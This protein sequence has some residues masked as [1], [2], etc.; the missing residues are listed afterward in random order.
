MFFG[1][2]TSIILVITTLISVKPFA[3]NCQDV[4]LGEDISYSNFHLSSVQL[5]SCGTA[6]SAV[7]LNQTVSAVHLINWA[8][9]MP[10]PQ[11]ML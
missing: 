4:F 10:T 8:G 11:I 7:H 6:V 3:Q 5:N 9:K 1:K 2:N